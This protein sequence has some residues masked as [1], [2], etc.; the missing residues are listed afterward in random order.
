MARGISLVR[1]HMS[2]PLRSLSWNVFKALHVDLW[3]DQTKES[4]QL[5]IHVLLLLYLKR[6][7]QLI[8]QDLS[9]PP[10]AGLKVAIVQMINV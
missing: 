10:T 4:R 2:F 1:N 3:A 6:C 9:V 8:K 5:Q 7:C